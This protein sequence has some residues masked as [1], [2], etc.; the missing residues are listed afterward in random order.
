MSTLVVQQSA[1]LFLIVED[2]DGGENDTL[3]FEILGSSLLQV[4]N[5][6]IQGPPGPPSTGYT[7]VQSSPSSTWTINHNLG[8]VPSSV[9]ILSPGGF[10][11]DAEVAYNGVNQVIVYFI[12]PYAGSA[13]IS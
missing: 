6:G 1:P 13:R 11:V 12:E 5:A 10:E 7:F 3:V 2:E 9:T 4:L 8:Y